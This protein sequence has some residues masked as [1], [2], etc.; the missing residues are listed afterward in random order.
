[1]TLYL[2]SF[3]HVLKT[4]YHHLQMMYIYI[5]TYKKITTL[6]SFLSQPIIKLHQC[7]HPTSKVPS[8]L[9]PRSHLLSFIQG[10][11]SFGYLLSF[12]YHKISFSSYLKDISVHITS[13]FTILTPQHTINLLLF[14][15][16][17]IYCT[18]L[19]HHSFSCTKFMDTFLLS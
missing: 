5:H 11:H 19:S 10:C 2:F 1:M 15:T 7:F 9:F 14:L 16:C 18:S 3:L 12:M 4:L 13:V 6:Y 8:S 17:R